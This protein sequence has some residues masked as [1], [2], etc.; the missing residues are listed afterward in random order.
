MKEIK[1]QSPLVVMGV[2]EVVVV[3]VVVR[4]Q[5]IFIFLRDFVHTSMAA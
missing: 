2:A 1:G 5:L 3:V 4:R